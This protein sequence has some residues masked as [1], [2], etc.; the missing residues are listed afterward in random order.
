MDQVDNANLTF[1]SPPSY[2]PQNVGKQETKAEKRAR[3]K[4]ELKRSVLGILLGA[5]MLLAKRYDLYPEIHSPE[6]D[7]VITVIV[8]LFVRRQIWL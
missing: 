8:V 2:C 5:G 6:V 7:I 3:Q 4:D 1:T